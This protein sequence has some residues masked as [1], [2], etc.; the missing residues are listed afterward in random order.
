[1]HHHCTFPQSAGKSMCVFTH[2][3][4]HDTG[5]SSY[6]IL[7][8]KASK[9]CHNAVQSSASAPYFYPEASSVLSELNGFQCCLSLP[10]D[11]FV[12]VAQRDVTG[13]WQE[14][15]LDLLGQKENSHDV[16][17]WQ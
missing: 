10:S 13:M 17:S 1:M 3:G 15:H 14:L 16:K 2:K 4:R 12:T 5:S 8:F 11:S 9:D 7:Q 6:N